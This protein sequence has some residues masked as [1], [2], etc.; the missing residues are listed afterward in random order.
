M[1]SAC[2]MSLGDNLINCVM[3][4]G[5]NKGQVIFYLALDFHHENLFMNK[6]Q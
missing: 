4:R 3:F 6:S 2:R 1:A 5:E